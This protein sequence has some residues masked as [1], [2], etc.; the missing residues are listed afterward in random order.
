M[1]G[2]WGPAGAA[3]GHCYPLNRVLRGTEHG[4]HTHGARSHSTQRNATT[5]RIPAVE[6]LSMVAN[7]CAK[8]LDSTYDNRGDFLLGHALEQFWRV[9][10]P[11]GAVM[12]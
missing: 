5:Q 8:G 11:S 12:S 10:R 9:A 7:G 2:T 4:A 1:E 6:E 3:T